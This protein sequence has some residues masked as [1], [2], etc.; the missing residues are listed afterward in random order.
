M[1][2]RGSHIFT[3]KDE[4]RIETDDDNRFY[5]YAVKIMVKKVNEFL[6]VAYAACEDCLKLRR[7]MEKN[8][9]HSVYFIEHYAQSAKLAFHALPM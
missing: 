7:A 8:G 2:R 9:Q 6:H 4:I 5:K 1:R 3:A